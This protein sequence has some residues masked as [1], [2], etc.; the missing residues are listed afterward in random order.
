VF[1][2]V[3]QEGAQA[4]LEEVGRLGRIVDAFSAYAQL[5]APRLQ[6]ADL[7]QILSPVAGLFAGEGKVAVVR[8]QAGTAVPVVADP[9]LLGQAFR[10][11]L[12]NCREALGDEGG[13]IRIRT[14]VDQ[15][16][17]VVEISDTGPGFTGEALDR[18]FDP[19]FTTREE[20]TGLGMA[21]TERIVTEHGGSVTA[22]N[23][24]DGGA[25]FTVSIPLAGSA[26]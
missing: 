18:L 25:R 7:D 12:S 3:F 4:V 16:C 9:D 11:I 13:E 22:G 19:Y 20:G 15:G 26:T 8:V 17:G 14:G 21:I 1:D 23:G 2:P 6:E 24:P 5:P 10:N